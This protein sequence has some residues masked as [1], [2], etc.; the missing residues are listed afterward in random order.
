MRKF[1]R[2]FFWSHGAPLGYLG[3]LSQK[4]H[5]E[6]F[7]KWVLTNLSNPLRHPAPLV[8]PLLTKNLDTAGPWCVECQKRVTVSSKIGIC[9]HSIILCSRS[10]HYKQLSNYYYNWGSLKNRVWH[11]WLK[12]RRALMTQSKMVTLVCRGSMLLGESLYVELFFWLVP[13]VSSERSPK[14]GISDG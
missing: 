9:F 1:L 6:I 13:P 8:D 4:G 5:P 3:S 11:F 14:F 7:S 12:S 2:I 10:M